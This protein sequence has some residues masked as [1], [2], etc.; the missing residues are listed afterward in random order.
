MLDKL[1]DTMEKRC[2]TC[3]AFYRMSFNYDEFEEECIL[4]KDIYSPCKHSLL[5]HWIIKILLKRHFKKEDKYWDKLIEK[6]K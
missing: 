1:Y 4:Q 3:P 5:P 2:E 6:D